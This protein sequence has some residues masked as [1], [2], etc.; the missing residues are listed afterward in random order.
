MSVG[1]HQRTLADGRRQHLLL[2]RGADHPESVQD[3]VLVLEAHGG[4]A[5]LER[6]EVRR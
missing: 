3:P 1:D 2:R 5:I 6:I 4:R